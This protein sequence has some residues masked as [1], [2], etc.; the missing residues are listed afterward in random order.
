MVVDRE[1]CLGNTEC[2]MFC[3]DACPYSAPQFG[4]EEGA[5]IQM[6]HLCVD[7]WSEGKR[8]I[9]IDSCPMRALDAGPLDE[10]QAKYGD[11]RE[12]VGFTYVRENKPSV[13]FKAR[14]PELFG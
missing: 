6:C 11:I 14:E 10:L 12:V 4:A 1:V 7:R 3:K 5:K 13:V 8:P 2:G 9:C